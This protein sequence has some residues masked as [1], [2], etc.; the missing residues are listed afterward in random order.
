MRVFELLLKPKEP[1]SGL[2]SKTISSRD[3]VS[4]RQRLNRCLDILMD[5][6]RSKR[7]KDILITRIQTDLNKLREFYK[8][9]EKI[10]E[11]IYK[12]PL[13]DGDFELLKS[14]MSNP[15]PAAVHSIYVSQVINDD[16]LNEQLSI[17]EEQTPSKDI[18]PFLIEWMERVMP[19]QMYRFRHSEPKTHTTGELSP[20][21]GYDPHVYRSASTEVNGDAYGKF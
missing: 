11:A 3:L 8:S 18:R 16:E 14:L 9:H 10:T 19:D 15:I 17:V 12:L 5:P 2:R 7:E 1:D 6:S 20:I 21:H 13:S 4:A